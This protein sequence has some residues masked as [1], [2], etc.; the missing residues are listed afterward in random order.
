MMSVVLAPRGGRGDLLSGRAS[1]AI[2]AR[3][4]PVQVK[5]GRLPHHVFYVSRRLVSLVASLLKSRR[6]TRCLIVATWSG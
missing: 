6:A 5:S 2:V 3:A 1:C 4:L